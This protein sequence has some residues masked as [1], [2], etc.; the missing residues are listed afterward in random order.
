MCP[1]IS[2][3]HR[4]KGNLD[5]FNIDTMLM[6]TED[7]DGVM[8][9]EKLCFS[10]PWTRKAFIDELTENKLAVYLVAKHEGKVIGYA[11]MWKIY[12]EGHIT[13]VAVHPEYRKNK[14]ASRLVEQLIKTA[15]K[16][17]I[18]KMT[19]EVRES[20]TAAQNL[21]LKYGFRAAG[22]RKEYY[23]DER[24]NAIIMWKEDV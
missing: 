3:S 21:Y 15:K 23:A 1:S 8:M 10:I 14:V 11:G 13:N 17:G 2:A 19:L 18:T 24:E 22:I 9:V 16:N 5:V 12:D 20:N 7:V 6:S 4:Q